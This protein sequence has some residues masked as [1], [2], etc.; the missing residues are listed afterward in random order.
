MAIGSMSGSVNILKVDNTGRSNLV[1]RTKIHTA[2]IDTVLSLLL[3]PNSLSSIPIR[4][5]SMTGSQSCFYQCFEFNV[6]AM[7]R[8]YMSYWAVFG[9]LI[10]TFFLGYHVTD[11]F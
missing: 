6:E 9:A 5:P 3:K 7:A 1:K 10:G 2:S 8:T 4:L 11:H